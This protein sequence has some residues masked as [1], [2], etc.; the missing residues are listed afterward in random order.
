MKLTN[1]FTLDE[2]LHSQAASRAGIDNTPLPAILENIKQ[3]A[4]G[5]QRVRDFLGF[6]IIV[7]SWYRNSAVNKIVGGAKNSSHMQGWAIDFTCPTFG[8]PLKVCQAIYK[9]GIGFDQLIHEYGAWVHISF[10]PR[11][12]GELLTYDSFGPPRIGLVSVRTA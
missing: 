8:P 3:A 6:P 2:S 9:N 5:L 7:S 4:Q 10:D 1:S 12:R 11:M